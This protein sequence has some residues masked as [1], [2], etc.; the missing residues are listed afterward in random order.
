MTADFYHL[1]DERPSVEEVLH[2]MENAGLTEGAV[3][4]LDVEVNIGSGSSSTSATTSVVDS[5]NGNEN[6][7]SRQLSLSSNNDDGRRALQS[8]STSNV[9]IEIL[10]VNLLNFDYEEATCP[11]NSTWVGGSGEGA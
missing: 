7:D 11:D 4:L 2:S 1:P 3:T 9:R 10:E 8:S 5:S 6:G